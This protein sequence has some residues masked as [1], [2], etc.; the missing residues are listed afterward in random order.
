MTSMVP[1]QGMQFRGALVRW[2]VAVSMALL[3]IAYEF[4]KKWGIFPPELPFKLRERFWIDLFFSETDMFV[5]PQP[6]KC[7]EGTPWIHFADFRARVTKTWTWPGF[8]LWPAKNKASPGL[9]RLPL[10]MFSSGILWYQ[11]ISVTRGGGGSTDQQMLFGNNLGYGWIW[12]YFPFNTLC[13]MYHFFPCRHWVTKG[14]SST[15]LQEMMCIL[16]RVI[17]L[18]RDAR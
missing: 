6:L 18:G 7:T 4:I 16:R 12:R 10:Y 5:I 1:L 15:A 9:A 14:W 2:S 8:L 3:K 13:T 17:S 11:V